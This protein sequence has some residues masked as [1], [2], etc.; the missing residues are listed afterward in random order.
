LCFRAIYWNSEI[1]LEAGVG[2]AMY[3]FEN[4]RGQHPIGRAT[5]GLSGDIDLPTCSV[6]NDPAV[7][8]QL[9]EMLYRYSEWLRL[10]IWDMSNTLGTVWLG[11][12]GYYNPVTC[13]EPVVVD[14]D[15]P[16]D[17]A[18]LG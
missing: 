9:T 17:A 2:Q 14:V 12:E 13:A 4:E 3:V 8:S 10:R 18:F 15:I 16:Q 11:V 5:I 1:Q 7:Q 6:G